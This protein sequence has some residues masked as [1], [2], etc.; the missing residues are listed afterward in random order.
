M[1]EQWN[2]YKQAHKRQKEVVEQLCSKYDCYEWEI[3][4]ER[5]KEKH[6]R[7]E[8]LPYVKRHL[9]DGVSFSDE[10]LIDL[11]E[12]YKLIDEESREQEELDIDMDWFDDKPVGFL[13]ELLQHLIGNIRSK[14]GQR[15]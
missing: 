12:K 11:M 6:R 10:V 8:V 2:Y 7:K 14:A 4:T 3:P 9:M 1:E 15:K 5:E 13:E